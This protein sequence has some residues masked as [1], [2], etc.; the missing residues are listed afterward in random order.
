MPNISFCSKSYSH[1][2]IELG[3]PTLANHSEGQ[4]E[5]NTSFWLGVKNYS[6]LLLKLDKLQTNLRSLEN[7]L[8]DNITA[9]HLSSKQNQFVYNWSQINDYLSQRWL[10]TTL[11]H[12]HGSVVKQEGHIMAFSGQTKTFL[13][14]CN[15]GHKQCDYSSM[16]EFISVNSLNCYTYDSS[17][18]H[19]LKESSVQGL[20]NGITFIF[21][22]GGNLLASRYNAEWTVPGLNNTFQPSAGSD[23]I[24]II[25]HD[26][27]V[28]AH[29]DIGGID[30]A[31]GMSTTIAVTSKESKMLPPPHG[32][33]S[34][35]DA[36]AALLRKS[37]KD[38]LGFE[39]PKHQGVRPSVYNTAQ[40]RATCLLRHI[41]ENCGCLL[42]SDGM[43]FVNHTLLCGRIDILAF[44]DPKS[45]CFGGRIYGR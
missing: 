10:V 18:G 30:V 29:P 27:D 9:N 25:V 26:K 42:S 28:A 11:L 35:E 15:R 8:K 5:S 43:P 17:E 33:C 20:K 3:V 13:V 34:M 1:L 6:T 38:K 23:G 45:K 4:L 16:N 22:T 2:L 14:S 41:W 36:E 21:M 12:K 31:P 24:K 37:V 7:I 32:Q 19:P 40:C 44:F 39:P